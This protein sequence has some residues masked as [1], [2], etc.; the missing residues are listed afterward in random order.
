MIYHSHYQLKELNAFRTEAY[1]KLYCEP[2]SIEEIRQVILDYPDE[3]KLIVGAGCNMF[4]TEDFDGLV[5]KP[6]LKGFR[7]VADEEDS[8]TIE[9]M[10]S[11]D[12]D[13]FVGYCVSNGY[14]GLE[15]L[16]YIPGSVGAAPIQNIGAYGAEV[17]DC[18]QEVIALDIYTGESFSFSNSECEFGYRESMFKKTRRYIV[19][20]VVFKLS[21][22]FRYQEKYVDLNRELAEIDEPT[23]QEVRDAVIRVRKRKLPDHR[24]LPNCG[25]FFKNPYISTEKVREL[26]ARFDT[27][28]LYPVQE[29]LLKTSAAFLIDKAGFKGVRDGNMGTYPNQ[30]LI[31]VN[32]GSADGKEIVRF[33]EKIRHEVEVVFGVRL[34]P[35]VWIF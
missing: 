17:K 14:A 6:N 25:S 34:E 20:S 28:P 2:Q 23:L 29:G 11:E 7:E 33:M 35:E 16:S 18:L 21:T 32:Y 4:F 10:A 15:N 30:P 27:I 26:K 24:E 3:K 8:V 31:L 12:W 9:V 5:L 1:A 19:I 13:N 22:C